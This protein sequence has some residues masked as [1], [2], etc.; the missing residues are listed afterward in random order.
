[1]NISNTSIQDSLP[2]E[3][4][5]HFSFT[6]KITEEWIWVCVY[7]IS[8]VLV[9]IL[10]VLMLCSFCK[11]GFLRTANTH[12]AIAFLAFRN[13]IR[14]IFSIALLY[15]TKFNYTF[16]DFK[17]FTAF[18]DRDG[19]PLLCD[20]LCAVDNFLL[21][22]PMFVIVSLAV[23]MFTRYP[24]PQ[25]GPHTDTNLKVYGQRH[26]KL[27]TGFLPRESICLGI[28]LPGLPLILAGLVA[29]PIPLM[30]LTHTLEVIPDMF[31]CKDSTSHLT[32]DISIFILQFCLP[33]LLVLFLGI[34]LIVR[35]CLQCSTH[36]CCN[37]WCKEEGVII[38]YF[39]LVSLSQSLYY[40]PIFEQFANK[41][42]INNFIANYL[43][44]WISPQIARAV[45]A[46][47]TGGS[48]PLLC[49]F[50]LPTYRQFTTEPDADD[51]KLSIPD[52]QESVIMTGVT[53][54]HHD[55]L[56]ASH[57]TTPGASH[58]S[59]EPQHQFAT[60]LTSS[61][62]GSGSHKRRYQDHD[63]DDDL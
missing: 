63:F 36:H 25:L 39:I 40:L 44:K 61:A 23:H 42:E 37:S 24:S 1:M 20:I 38:C 7:G 27:N 41:I 33:F 17:N 26:S 21:A 15:I 57:P 58:R 32:F 29:C 59:L 3:V 11:N 45:E 51:L 19:A 5:G 43:E 47:I 60:I 16:K 14:S 18:S 50:F 46:G 8:V 2:V 35:R 54:S 55:L 6:N 48:L 9:I 30:H 31:I 49:F 53:T 12:R 62:Y 13:V 52:G 34:G 10:N 56:P 22:Y 28:V 4:E